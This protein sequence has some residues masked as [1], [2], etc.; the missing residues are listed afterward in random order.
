[1]DLTLSSWMDRISRDYLEDFIPLG[2]AAVKFG[3]LP[4]EADRTAAWNAVRTQAEGRGYVFVV[5]DA[6][7]AK[8]HM[9]HRLFHQIARQVDWEGL[10]Q[11]FLLRVFRQKGYP[12]SDPAN[13]TLERIAALYNRQVDFLRRDCQGWLEEEIFRDYAMAQE[14]RI[15]ML[16]LCLGQLG[17]DDWHRSLRPALKEWLLGDLKHIPELKSAL[18]FEKI[19]RHN[20][21]NMLHSLAHWLRKC[22][23]KGLVLG[24]DI[25]QC[26]AIRKEGSCG[27]E[28]FYSKPAVLDMYEVLRQFIDST[29][30][31]EGVFVLVLAPPAF[32]SDPKRGLDAYDAL[33]LRIVDEVRDAA[34]SNP[35]GALVRLCPDSSPAPG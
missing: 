12:V 18:I 13:L 30:D 3:I 7:K 14:F 33:R 22:E 10:A 4:E 8:I 25:A 26:F 23:R 20:A 28:L 27:D 16:H 19:Q 34:R 2:G 32:L 24:L 6:A 29:D 9:M 21:R 31:L 17:A 35:F 1:M 11:S 5:A 15:A